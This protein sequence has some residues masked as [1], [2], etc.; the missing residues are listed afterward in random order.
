MDNTSYTSSDNLHTQSSSVSLL[1]DYD[2]YCALS[3]SSLL[4]QGEIPSAHRRIA[5]NYM[6]IKKIY[7]FNSLQYRINNADKALLA[8][9][10]FNPL[11]YCTIKQINEEIEYLKKW[12][13]S[14]D[15]ILC[16]EADEILNIRLRELKFLVTNKYAIVSNELYNG[17]MAL[18]KYFETISKY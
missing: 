14:M 17:Y 13:F 5:D 10:D 9:Y 15:E 6:L 4:A 1:D 7:G 2:N 11:E 8:K 18:E 3:M 16:K 12:S